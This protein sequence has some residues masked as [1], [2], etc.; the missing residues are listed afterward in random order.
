[1]FGNRE[2]T[3][4][5]IWDRYKPPFPTSPFEGREKEHASS[6]F[7]LFFPFGEVKRGSFFLSFH[8]RRWLAILHLKH[9][10]MKDFFRRYWTP[11]WGAVSSLSFKGISDISQSPEVA[12]IAEQSLSHQPKLMSYFLI[13]V[14]GALG[15]LLVKIAW[16]VC[17]KV[18]PK[19]KNIDK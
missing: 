6:I 13:G 7:F 11:A 19:L 5:R 10:M 2:F 18:F 16:G 4:G 9:K 17:K 15:G 1:M 12:E 14:A 3:V 8:L